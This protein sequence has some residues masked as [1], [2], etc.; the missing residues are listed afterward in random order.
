VT[1]VPTGF[2]VTVDAGAPHDLAAWW[3]DTLGWEV[4]PADESFVRKMIARGARRRRVLRGVKRR[5]AL[6]VLV[7]PG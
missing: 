6:V 3:A 5:F 1:G 2:Q 4:E 7:H